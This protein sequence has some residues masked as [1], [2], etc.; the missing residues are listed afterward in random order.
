MMN[1]HRITYNPQKQSCSLYFIGCNFRC[2]GCYWK[3]IY[4]RVKLNELRFTTKK[5]VIE[6]L[7]K[8]IPKSVSILSGDPASSPDYLGLPK[9]LREEIGCK[10]R[11]LTNGYILPNLAGVTHVSMSIKAQ[12][13][14]LHKKYTGKSNK[15]CLENFRLVHRQKIELSV[16]SVLIPSLIEKD[17]IEKIAKFISSVDK[18]I[19]FRII[20]YMKVNGLPYREPNCEELNETADKARKYLK[21]VIFSRSKGED[22]TGVVDLFTNN[23]RR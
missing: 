1:I 23:L 3:Q 18:N 5:E 12:D 22:Y 8:A 6:L 17:E 9:L 4:G 2:L 7:R 11:L 16:S 19:P 10:V 21:N 15:I 13:E 20:G 14:E